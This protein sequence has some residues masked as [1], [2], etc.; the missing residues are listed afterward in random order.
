MTDGGPPD[1]V[2]IG[3]IAAVAKWLFSFN[4][5]DIKP[6]TMRPQWTGIPY[7]SDRLGY[8]PMTDGRFHVRLLQKGVRRQFRDWRRRR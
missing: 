5:G 8:H 4:R 2:T 1:P 6:C 3:G 7:L